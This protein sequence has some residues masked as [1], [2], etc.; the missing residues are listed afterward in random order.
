MPVFGRLAP[1]YCLKR[2]QKHLGD[3]R[4]TAAARGGRGRERRVQ[5]DGPRNYTIFA[6]FVAMVEFSRT[7]VWKRKERR[8]RRADGICVPQEKGAHWWE[9][10]LW[11]GP[12]L[13]YGSLAEQSGSSLQ[14]TSGALQN[15]NKHW[16]AVHNIAAVLPGTT[17]TCS[18]LRHSQCTPLLSPTSP[19]A[20]SFTVPSSRARARPLPPPPFHQR[21]PCTMCHSTPR[22]H[23]SLFA[24][25]MM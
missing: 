21:L 8:H 15:N 7:R 23:A 19:G 1:P 16:P 20:G 4:R 2:V 24:T 3:T 6:S 17:H 22:V 14:A 13:R 12:R 25:A 11:P 9:A 10:V 5:A 18:P